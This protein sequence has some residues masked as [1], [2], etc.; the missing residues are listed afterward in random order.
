[1]SIVQY[2]AQQYEHDLAMGF[3]DLFTLADIRAYALA[4]FCVRSAIQRAFFARELSTLCKI[5]L[6]ESQAQALDPIYQAGEVPFVQKVADFVTE[7]ATVL[8]KMAPEI[9]RF[10]K[11]HF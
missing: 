6:E 10:K 3:G 1:V 7:R 5:A 8:L 11:E 4:D 2:D 9:S